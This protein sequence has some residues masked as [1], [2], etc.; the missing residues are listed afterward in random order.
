MSLIE[1]EVAKHEMV[2]N[3]EAY[4]EI[5]GVMTTHILINTQNRLMYE[6]LIEASSTKEEREAITWGV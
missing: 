5:L 4:K 6:E 3:I 1:N 2:I